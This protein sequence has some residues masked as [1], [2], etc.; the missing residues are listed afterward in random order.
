MQSPDRLTKFSSPPLA[1]PVPSLFLS[2]FFSCFFA[3]VTGVPR[4]CWERG[5][6]SWRKMKRKDFSG[7]CV[8]LEQC[9]SYE[10]PVSSFEAGKDCREEAFDDEK[11][12]LRCMYTSPLRR[13]HLIPP[14]LRDF[15][16]SFFLSLSL[17]QCRHSTFSV[18]LP[19]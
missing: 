8:P 14:R 15:L 18:F 12:L 16:T 10:S 6:Q 1:S 3:D 5:E 17:L 13:F 19:R 7:L 4:L 2:T 9:R 11:F